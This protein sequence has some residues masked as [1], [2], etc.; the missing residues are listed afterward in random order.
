MPFPTPSGPAVL[1]DNICNLLQIGARLGVSK[2]TV[3]RWVKDRK[4]T[5]FPEPLACGVYDYAEVYA[6][7][8]KWVIAHPAN[9]PKAAMEIMQRSVAE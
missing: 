5:K 1:V 8:Q 9:Y 4:F 7:F 3:A 2:N 6:R